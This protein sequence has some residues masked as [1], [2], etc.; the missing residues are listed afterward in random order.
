MSK[1]FIAIYRLIEKFKIFSLFILVVILLISAFFAS[2]LKL[3]ED[4][5]K[6]LPDTDKINNMNFVYSN[7][8]FM[9]KVVFNISLKDTTKSNPNLL[10]DFA[11]RLTDSINSRYVPDLVQSIDF[12]PGQAEMMEVYNTVL[13]NLPLF[14]T[15]E[16]YKVIDTLIKSENIENALATNYSTLMSPVSFITKKFIAVD[17]L[18]FTPIALNKFKSANID[19]D[20]QIYNR[21]FISD[22]KRNIIFLLT[23]TSTNKTANNNILFDGIDDIIK[24]LTKNDYADIRV[25]YFGNAVVA[26]GNANQIKKDIIITVTLAMIVLILVITL[27]FRSK[28]TFF[29]VFLP[30]AFGALVSLAMLFIL[31]KEISAIS[32]GIG[33][34]LL[35]I[36]VD[37]ALHIYSHFRQH[38]SHRL[39]FKN[40]ST[41]VILSS[42]TTASAFLSLY[43]VNSEALNDLGLF[44]AISIISAALFSLIVLPHLTGIKKGQSIT[45]NINWIDKIAGFNFSKNSVLKLGIVVATIVLFFFSKQV[46]FDADMMKNNYMSDELKQVEQRLNKVTNLSKKTIYIVSPG[47]NPDDAMENNNITSKLINK[48]I[49]E[50][51]I[52]NAS[53]VNNIFPSQSEQVK[54]INRWN[55]Y[56]KINGEKVITEINTEAQALGFRDGAFGK[57]EAWIKAEFKPVSF[58]DTGVIN[59]LFLENFI[60]ETDTLSAIIN[61]VKV[62]NRDEDITKVYDTFNENQTAW[63]I[64]KRLITSEFVTILK[65]NFNKLVLISISLVFIILLLAY[66][67]IELTIITM[68]PM[69]LS[70]IWTVGIMGI[71]GIEFNIF[72]IIILTFIFG[73][74]IDYSIFIM[75]GLLLEYKYGIHDISSYKVSVILSGITTL[76]GIGVLI[77]AAHP[78]LRS[79]ATMSIIGILSVIFITFT[80]LPAIFKWLVTYKKGLRNRPI[81][82]VDFLFSMWAL[83]VFVSGSIILS[84]ISLLFRVVPIPTKAKKLFIHK[85]FRYLTWF[86]IYM[87][88]VSK[89]IIINPNNEDYTKP[90]IIIAN[91][92]SHIDLM[93][94]MLL[95]HRV[96]V[97]TNPRNF[98]NPIYGPALRYA[99]FIKVGGDYESIINQV[100]KQTDEGYSVVIFPEGHR[101]EGGKLKRFHKGAFYLASELNLDILPIIIYG[102]KE[103]LKKS[104]FFLKRATA[105]T[106]F[107]PRIRLSDGEYGITARD[108]AKNVKKYF[109]EE[110]YKVATMLETPDYF[111][112]FIKKNFLYKGPVLE[113][114]TRIKLNLEDNYNIFNDLIPKKCT[115]T[116]LGCG[117]GYLPLMLNLVSKDRDITGID[118][119]ADK[120]GVANHCAIKSDNANFL[121]G[122]I[123]KV[124]VDYSDVF[125]M[126]DVLHYLPEKSQIEVVE[127]CIKKLNGNG[128]IIIRDANKD[129]V[130]RHLGT[131]ITEL[132]STNLGFNKAEFKLEFVSKSMIETIA[133]NHNF[134]LRII[135]NTK[136]TSN[137]IYV[138]S[139]L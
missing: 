97:L 38:G 134:K 93:L 51:T 8:K 78:A 94:M 125:I 114:Y 1:L 55:S 61:V 130:N 32:L 127:S 40:L 136:R 101:S 73:L 81:T 41:P 60:I 36:S 18:Y 103:A 35:G 17:P 121:T 92:Q 31:K 12:A 52:Q 34:V 119:D 87:N 46:G 123:T 66:G 77:F 135:D 79:I 26:L 15:E 88:F 112:D 54:A 116:D 132:F 42:L 19:N 22:N 44:A 84:I 47:N 71:L 76:L 3:S 11:D 133:R 64:D 59:H 106:K 20:F 65:D 58:D 69:I 107:L 82:L 99:G 62:N 72:N 45:H 80:L 102:Q 110:Y 24:N 96:V 118:Y 25:D 105:V 16:D 113:W 131:R 120:I 67:R 43:F 86:M 98:S 48:L 75:R 128:L 91:H 33:S 122:D 104:E 4:I 109:E 124:D 5:T 56:W 100:K 68:I 30:V 57:F 50:G 63:I 2:Q 108:Q 95:N 10:S 139:L 85:L 37:Y 6:I 138:L 117:Y 27:F 23:P 21:Y 28:R 74:G 126:N 115:I 129:M 13:S 53:V 90:A 14:L 89:K 111:N 29:I 7:S 137:L 49:D 83:F 39:I 70:W 9:D